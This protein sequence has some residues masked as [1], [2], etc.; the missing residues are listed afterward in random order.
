MYLPL[1][2]A[3]A[4][5]VLA[6]HTLWMKLQ[7]KHLALGI[8]TRSLILTG[9]AGIFTSLGILTYL[10]NED[11]RDPMDLWR[12]VTEAVPDNPRGHNN[13]GF[14][15]AEAGYLKDAITQHARAVA[16]APRMAL[17]QSNYGLILAKNG[18]F[19]EALEHLR[20]AVQLEP[21]D[22]KFISNLGFVLF[23]KGSLD[24]AET[25][26]NTA[27]QLNPMDEISYAGLASVMEAKHEGLKARGLI[28]QC[29]ALNPY[30]PAFR[31]QQA[32][33][34]LDLGDVHGAR[35]A[36]LAA[37]RLESSAEKISN[38][39]W[40]MHD[41]SLDH[42]ALAAERQALAMKPGDTKTMIRLAW[43]LAASSDASVR[44]GPEAVRLAEQVLQSQPIRSPQFLDLLAVSLAEAGRF[45]EARATLQEALDQ[46]KARQE[47]WL[48]KLE[49]QLSL[50]ERNE[51]FHE[52]AKSPLGSRP[53]K[54]G[55]Q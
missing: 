52:T 31:V 23:L 54:A 41:C 6:T 42:E 35:T 24:N 26:F 50:F 2:P 16:L 17:F 34:L 12:S 55:M 44:N 14:N 25:C 1:V 18:R 20:I 11:Y 3:I 4:S 32:F 9:V 29:I 30:N 45:Q 28:Q 47:S 7:A 46:A 38:L 40:S 49:T 27:R 48:P 51:P 22:S 19:P 33:I 43:I 8:M 15:L 10:R 37:L 36:F 53:A 21:T 13:Y 5:L 39:G